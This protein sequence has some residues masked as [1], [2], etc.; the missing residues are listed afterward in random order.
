[1]GSK[2][3]FSATQLIAMYLSKI[4]LVT[5]GELRLPVN[6]MVISCPAYFTDAQRRVMIDA[7][8]IAG[9]KVLQLINETTA[10]ALGWGITKTDLPDKEPGVK[11]RRAAF[12]DIGNSN[13]TV[14]IVDFVKGELKVRATAC[15]RHFGGRNFDAA[16]VDHF[17]KE[18][19]EKFKIDVNENLKARTRVVAAAEKL[20]KV[21]SA[22][23]SAPMNIESLMN[24]VDV[25]GSL[26]REEFEELIK[27][28]LDRAAAPL[29]QAL[30]DAKCTKDDI[31]VVE[32]VGG[33]T[34]LHDLQ[35]QAQA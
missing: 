18:F 12:I 8:E 10:T 15:D 5:S 31:D 19:K 16:I 6:D 3:K 35:V 27:P 14:T 9:L 7:A 11:P 23:A 2:Q 24:D 20:K 13:Y 30:A 17:A 4:K 22:N 32:L 21:L 29:E 34:R 25:R 33:C 28:L 26:K 1:M